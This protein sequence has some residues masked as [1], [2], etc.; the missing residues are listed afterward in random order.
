MCVCAPFIE[1]R[2]AHP[3]WLLRHISLSPAE[4]RAI[5]TIDADMRTGASSA[6]EKERRSDAHVGNADVRLCMCVDKMCSITCEGQAMQEKCVSMH[7][8]VASLFHAHVHAASPQIR[9]TQ[10][11]SRQTISD[12]HGCRWETRQAAGRTAK[13]T[14]EPADIGATNS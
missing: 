11:G 7:C 14:S 5:S 8:H 10:R 1:R 2:I 9:E 3:V 6:N 13:Q 12:A 4:S